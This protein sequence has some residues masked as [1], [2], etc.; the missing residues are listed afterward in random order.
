MADYIQTFKQALSRNLG[1]LLRPSSYMV[2]HRLDSVN[3]LPELMGEYDLFFLDRD[4]TLQEYHGD[5]I[6]E[7]FA[8]AIQT[9]AP[10]SEIISNSSFDEFLRLG[11]IFSSIMPVNKLVLLKSHIGGMPNLLRIED[12][13]LKLFCYSPSEGTFTDESRA[14][15]NLEHALGNHITYNFKKPDPLVLHALLD[16]HGRS[17]DTVTSIP[18]ALMVGDRYMTDIACGNLA[19][20]DTAKVKPYMPGSDPFGLKIGRYF[21]DTPVG[22]IMSRIAGKK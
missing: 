14:Y 6:P 4:C 11:G 8:E 13:V 22:A 1:D 7:E 15:G 17:R 2:T 21:L 16:Y 5:S 10:M 12:N 3:D 18:K 9:I 19:G 20:I